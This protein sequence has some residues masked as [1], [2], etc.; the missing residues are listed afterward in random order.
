MDLSLFKRDRNM[1][2]RRN[3]FK[4]L[5]QL[6]DLHNIF[7]HKNPPFECVVPLFYRR[8]TISLR[9]NEMTEKTESIR[10]KKPWTPTT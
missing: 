6:I 10:I 5:D 2:E 7:C 1:V 3:R 8:K 4:L 9:Q